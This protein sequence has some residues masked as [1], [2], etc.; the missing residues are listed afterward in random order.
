MV[1]PIYPL[2]HS[3]IISKFNI[4]SLFRAI[5]IVWIRSQ[6]TRVSGLSGRLRKK[7]SRKKRAATGGDQIEE[8]EFKKEMEEDWER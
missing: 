4:C 6:Q 1:S 7:I 2:N 3:Q 8:V 5:R